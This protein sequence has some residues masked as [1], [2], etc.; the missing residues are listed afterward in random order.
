M[1]NFLIGIIF[2]VLLLAS[3]LL[4]RGGF[5]L[6]PSFIISL[7]VCTIALILYI[8]KKKPNLK[9]VVLTSSGTGLFYILFASIGIKLFPKEQIRDIGDIVM[10]YIYVLV[11]SICTVV[12]FIFVGY[13]TVLRNSNQ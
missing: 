13:V 11:F 9:E 5:E 2:C 6:W 8:K 12:V 3:F 1:K 4:L 10:P 7:V